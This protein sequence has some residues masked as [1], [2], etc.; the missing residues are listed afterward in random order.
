MF[1]RAQ[2]L[3][4]NTKM[5]SFPSWAALYVIYTSARIRLAGRNTLIELSYNTVKLHIKSELYYH[6]TK[7]QLINQSTTLFCQDLI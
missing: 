6:Y 1:N 4:V 3:C 2:H 7:L 5:M